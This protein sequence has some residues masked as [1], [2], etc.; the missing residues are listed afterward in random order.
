MALRG[1]FYTVSFYCAVF[2]YVQAVLQTTGG[3]GG[4]P[5]SAGGSE[6]RPLGSKGATLVGGDFNGAGAMPL[7]F[8]FACLCNGF[9]PFL[10]MHPWLAVA[11]PS[12]HPS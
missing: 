4:Q 12:P 10:P 2:L 8:M 6:G 7:A 9:L 1:S 3:Q 5:T 11:F